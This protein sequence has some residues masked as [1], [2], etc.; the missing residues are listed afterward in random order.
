LDADS[1]AGVQVLEK[2]IN[3]MIEA[4]S[5]V[6][7]TSKAGSAEASP[8]QIEQLQTEIFNLRQT[9]KEKEQV[10]EEA[11]LT[12][13]KNGGSGV[14]S[15]TEYMKQIEDLKNRLSDYEVIAEDIADLQS[16]REENQ[17]LQAQLQGLGSKAGTPTVATQK[18]V[19]EPLS[20]TPALDVFSSSPVQESTETKTEDVAAE[21]LSEAVVAGSNSPSS[22]DLDNLLQDLSQDLKV[23]EVAGLTD[24][25]KA[26][27]QQF[28]KSK[29]S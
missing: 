17:K 10:A 27:I 18:S 6:I 3:Q 8:E 28:E 1:S 11:S 19:S 5:K 22:A 26:L 15:S 23:S 7:M 16:L 12:A 25:D 13:S 24:E 14:G 29:G 9:L 21:S 4:Q 2:K 20:E